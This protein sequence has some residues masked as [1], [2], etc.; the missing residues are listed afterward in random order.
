[1]DQLLRLERDVQAIYDQTLHPLAFRVAFHL[2]V[3]GK[4]AASLP[5][6][7]FLG[8]H[9][10]GKSSFINHL[11]G[12]ELQKTGL[13]PT[14]DG[15][16]IV[17][18]GEKE[19]EY[20]GQT[21][22]SHPDLAYQRL[23]RLGPVF[24]G[25]LRLKTHPSKLLKVINLIDSPG[26]IDAAGTTRNRGYDF[27][28]AVRSFAEM[29]DLV[30]FFFDPDKPGTTGESVSIFT[31]TL[32]GLEHKLLI[33]M[34]K[35]DLFTSIRDFARTYGTL[36]WN[37][38]KTMKTKDVPHIFNTCLPNLA[39]PGGAGERSTIPLEDFDASREEVIAEIER[40]PTRRADN[41]V[42]D[43]LV[44]A[45]CVSM[46]ARVCQALARHFVGLNAKIWAAVAGVVVL[47][48]VL[49]RLSWTA[50]HWSTPLGVAL[51]GMGLA[52]ATWWAGRSYVRRRRAQV[53]T[54]DGID[55]WFERAYR[56]ELTLQD[57]ADLRALWHKVRPMTLRAVS[58]L[59]PGGLKQ[60][61][62]L[63]R[64][65]RALESV[66]DTVIPKL[67][68]DIAELHRERRAVGG[69]EKRIEG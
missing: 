55:T 8:N 36:C 10:S 69:G 2:P 13:A 50:E 59:G 60:G 41:L 42:S 1:M 40:A 9:S 52:A 44:N 46:Q 27:A 24:L 57:R 16:T 48:A 32:V 38:S 30:L 14:D 33:V 58:V 63:G 3:S 47:A 26:M 6:V 31:E 28:D 20:D 25:R 53:A 56:R 37:L 22:V 29:A 68:R 5:T 64:Q 34:N 17:T 4:D 35:V 43:L 66:V 12:A 67:R 19:D 45:R 7:L 65:I 51:A 11:L 54:P 15:F 21:V 18:Y 62:T 49:V 61:Y 39:R 23:H